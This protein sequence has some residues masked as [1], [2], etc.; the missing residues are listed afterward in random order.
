MVIDAKSGSYY[1]RCLGCMEAGPE[2]PNAEIA[3][4]AL[5][6]FGARTEEQAATG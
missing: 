3:R 4:K 2:C 6:V 1:A 5:L